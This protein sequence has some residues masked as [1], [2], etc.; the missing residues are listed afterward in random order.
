MALLVKMPMKVIT[1]RMEVI[2][3][4]YVQYYGS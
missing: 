2:A 4:V 3:P 1:I